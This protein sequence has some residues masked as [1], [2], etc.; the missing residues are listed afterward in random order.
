MNSKEFLTEKLN[1]LFSKFEGVQIRYEYRVNTQ[2]HIVEVIPLNFFEG[3]E[4]MEAEAMIEEEFESLYQQENIVF[5]S[6]G[7]LTEIKHAELELGYDKIIL[8]YGKSNFEFEVSGFSE[9]VLHFDYQ[10]FAL[11][12]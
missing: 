7:S 8:D 6:E 9:I 11:A 1:E 12:A 10:N 3:N 5:I 4:Y 2:S